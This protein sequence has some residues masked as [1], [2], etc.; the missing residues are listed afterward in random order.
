M[1][2]KYKDKSAKEIAHESVIMI[3]SLRSDFKFVIEHMMG[4]EDRL[5]K[6]MDEKFAEHGQRL[7]VIEGV[8][9]HHSEMHQEHNRKFDLILSEMRP[10]THKVDQHDRDIS[11]L[12]TAI[13]Q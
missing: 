2:S 5:I 4:V 13:H 11:D 9:R 10:I 12:K 7:D 3:E 8:L 1:K 6:R